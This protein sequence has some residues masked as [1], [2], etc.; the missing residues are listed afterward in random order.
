M[1]DGCDADSSAPSLSVDGIKTALHC[2]RRYEFAHVDGLEGD[3]DDGALEARV[4]LLRTAICDALRSGETDRE[5]LEAVAEDRLSR[6]W[7]DHDEGFHSAA[8][9]RHERRVLEATLAAYVERVGTDHAAGI[10]RLDAEAGR[11]ELIGPALPLSSTIELPETVPGD[12]ERSSAS[13]A[14][15]ADTA[16]IDATVD[17]VYGD[18]SSIVGVRFVP[19][20]APL[21]RL[22]YRSDWEGD[23][24]DLFTDHFAEDAAAFEPA[25]IGALFETAVAL[26]GLRGL[27]DRLA[28]GDRTCRYVQIPLADRSTLS[29]N[30]VRDA[31]ETSLEVVDL[32]DVYVDHHTFGMTHDHRNETVDGQLETVAADLVAGSFD[33]AARWAQIEANSCPDCGYT[34]CCQ[35]YIGREVRFDG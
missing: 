8:Q 27:R 34:V 23:V 5:K 10:A 35:E 33:P 6:L 15:E 25:P 31:V 18:G 2:P 1:S 29:V 14:L 24:A 20:L 4:D 13:S 17:Y 3:E 21:G 30:W 28:L 12:G 22:R 7:R 19:T 16:T 32:T 11:G 9:R 26:D